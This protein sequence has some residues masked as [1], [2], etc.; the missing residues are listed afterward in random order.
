MWRGSAFCGWSFDRVYFD[1][2]SFRSFTNALSELPLNSPVPVVH[3]KGPSNRILYG[4]AASKEVNRVNLAR[5]ASDDRNDENH[6]SFAAWV[7][8]RARVQCRYRVRFRLWILN[9]THN[10]NGS[11]S[12][13]GSFGFLEPLAVLGVLAGFGSQELIDIHFAFW[14]TGVATPVDHTTFLP[15]IVVGN[16]GALVVVAATGCFG[17]SIGISVWTLCAEDFGTKPGGV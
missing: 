2:C 8:L 17:G 10:T 16:A 11:D 9:G 7:Y 1:N 6:A 15:L 4:L 14:V 5:L 12:A 13:K 3:A